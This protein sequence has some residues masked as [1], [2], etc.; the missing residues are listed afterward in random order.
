[1]TQMENHVKNHKLPQF[2]VDLANLLQRIS[3]QEPKSAIIIS[4]DH[5]LHY[6][7]RYSQTW[8]K[9]EHSLPVLCIC[10]KSRYL[11]TPV[12]I[13]PRKFLKKYPSI[14]ETMTTNQGRLINH[15]DTYE[16]IKHLL[17]FPGI[18]LLDLDSI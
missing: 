18:L 7:Y 14:A 16:T 9:I 1:M 11:I 12:I 17:S 4:G 13:L 3:I 2:D 5:G 6:G 15:Y 8:G 10:F